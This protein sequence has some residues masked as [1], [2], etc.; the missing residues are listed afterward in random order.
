[1]NNVVLQLEQCLE[2]EVDLVQSFISVLEEE[3]QALTEAGDTDAL[4]ESTVAKNRYADQLA[5]VADERQALLAQLGYPGDKPG[6]DAAALNHPQLRDLCKAL[7]EKADTASQLNASNGIVI[8][9]FLAH[10][11]QALDMVRGLVGASNLYD[12]SG[13]KN[14]AQPGSGKKFKAG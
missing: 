4:G 12:A 14:S 11:Q 3:A 6:L 10:N 7:L 13:R 8:N 9:T 1:M 2:Q 5:L